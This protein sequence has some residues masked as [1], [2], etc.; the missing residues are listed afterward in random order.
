L[1]FTPYDE[2]HQALPGMSKD[3]FRNQLPEM[4]RRRYLAQC[5]RNLARD[6][7]PPALNQVQVSQSAKRTDTQLADIQFRLSGITRPLD[8]YLHQSLQHGPLPKEDAIE[9][10]N[11]VHELLSDTASYITQ[12]RI[13]NMCKAAGI[14]GTAPR[15][16]APTTIPLLDPKVLLDH[17]NL[18]KT[19][20]QLGRHGQSSRRGKAHS[21]H[22]SE[23]SV[24]RTNDEHPRR[25]QPPPRKD[26]RQG[27]QFKDR[28]RPQTTSQ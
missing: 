14:R 8:F 21:S 17:A 27:H 16:S 9:F 6:Y 2:F 3:F 19:T 5:P 24:P 1:E 11:A 20:M 12:L 25:T 28:G 15:I 22:P 23:P 10:V 18:S 7:Q 13:D 4:E 26:F